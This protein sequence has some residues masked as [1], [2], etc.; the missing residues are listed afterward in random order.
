MSRRYQLV[1][2]PFGPF[3][4]LFSPDGLAGALLLHINRRPAAIK[5]IIASNWPD[6]EPAP[7]KF[8]GLRRAVK[9]YFH[10]KTTTFDVEI[11]LS[12]MTDFSQR[13]LEA[14]RRIPYGPP[15]RDRSGIEAETTDQ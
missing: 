13:V 3:V 2:T 12:G 7:L 8:A 9:S 15:G 1:E 4:G 11:D 10:G 5:R 6:A 14:C